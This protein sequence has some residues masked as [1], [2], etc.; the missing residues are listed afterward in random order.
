MTTK[1]KH[2]SK[3]SAVQN[4]KKMF[5]NTSDDSISLRDVFIAWGRNLEKEQ[6]N[7]AWLSNKLTHLKY[8]DL[9][10]PIY[11]Y[12]GGPRKLKKLELTLEGKRELGRIKGKADNV[13]GFIA[14][15]DSHSALPSAPTDLYNLVAQWKK[16]HPD[17][18]V[19]FDVKLKGF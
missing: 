15:T 10:T 14:S 3:Y 9:V 4:T 6:E 11:S 12:D 13:N 1:L 16:D 8:H 2:K 5:A 19:T 7:K 17:F 18:E